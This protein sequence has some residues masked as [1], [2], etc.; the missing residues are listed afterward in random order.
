MHV[1]NDSIYCLFGGGDLVLY[2]NEKGGTSEKGTVR[3]Y[4]ST[5]VLVYC[6]LSK[7]Y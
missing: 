5:R 3:G 4:L 6:H 7:I 2:Q 1:N